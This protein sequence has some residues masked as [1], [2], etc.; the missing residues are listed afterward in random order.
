MSLRKDWKEFI[1][2]LNAN[3]VDYRWA[4]SPSLCAFGFSS[5]NLRIEDFLEPG[6]TGCPKDLVDLDALLGP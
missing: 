4:L 2:S 5:L 6:E 1:E 3:G